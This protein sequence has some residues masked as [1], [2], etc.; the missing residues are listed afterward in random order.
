MIAV[1]VILLDQL[2]KSVVAR[3]LSFPSEQ[4]VLEGFFKLVHW[5]NTGSAFSMFQDR[6]GILALV[7]VGAIAL[8]YLTRH[9]FDADT[10]P[11]QLALGLIFG[12]IVGNLVD[13]MIHQHVID[14]I[15][16]YVTRRDGTELGFPA[17]NIADSA[18]CVGVGL[19]FVLAWLKPGPGS[20][21]QPAN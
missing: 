17:F 18:I 7:S 6:N 2:T 5:G 12:G 3:H 11:G 13:R 4:V 15:Y 8:L 1:A 21:E 16:F 20:T 14:F 9:H 19:L 10:V